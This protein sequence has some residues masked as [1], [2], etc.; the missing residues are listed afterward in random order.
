MPD[1]NNAEHVGQS[2]QSDN[3]EDKGVFKKYLNAGTWTAIFTG[4][5]I[6]FSGLL[7]RVNDKANDTSIATQRAFVSFGGP[8]F[9]KDIQGRKLKGINV[10][11]AM[12][13]SGTTP[14]SAAILEWNMSIGPTSPQKGVDFDT[15]SQNERVP[16][17]LGPKAGFQ[18]KPVYLSIEDLEMVAENKKH[19]FFWGWITYRDIFTD[20]PERLSEFC[21]DI[22]SATWTRPNHTDPT[23]DF[24]TDSPPCPIHNCYDKQCEDY[25]KRTQ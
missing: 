25:T 3:T 11:Y 18:M 15:L 9:V 1:T 24:K 2:P 20:T 21:T 16:L 12:S 5:L 22:A 8:I 10:Y 13:N 17:V 23:I 4:V 6:V 7:W 19:L 14:V